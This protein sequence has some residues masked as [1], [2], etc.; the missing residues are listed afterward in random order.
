MK[1]KFLLSSLFVAGLLAGCTTDMNT[2]TADASH[3]IVTADASDTIVT[4]EEAQRAALAKVP[5]TVMEGKMEKYKG[6]DYWTFDIATAG[7][8]KI[9]E[10][11]VDPHTGKVVWSGVE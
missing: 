5:G 11:A 1:I 10:V 9:T 4:K 6:K 7:T 8:K 2:K 3:T